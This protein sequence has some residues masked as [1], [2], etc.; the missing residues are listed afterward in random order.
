MRP[1]RGQD[2]RGPRPKVR[3]VFAEFA[4]SSPS[5]PRT[6]PRSTGRMPRRFSCRARP[7]LRHGQLRRRRLQGRRHDERQPR[8]HGV[9]GNHPRHPARRGSADRHDPHPRR[10]QE[11]RGREEVPGLHGLGRGADQVERGGGPAADQQERDRD[12]DDPFLVAGFEMLSTATGGIAQF[13]DRDAP[14]EMAKA[15]MEGFQQ[16]MV[17]PEQLDAILSGSSRR[18]SASTSDLTTRGRPFRGA[19]LPRFP[20]GPAWRS[21]NPPTDRPDAGRRGWWRW[22]QQRLTP[23]LFLAPGSSCSRSTCSGRSSRASGCRSTTGTGSTRRE[24]MDRLG[25]LPELRTDPAFETSLRNNVI[26]LVLYMLAMPGGA[27]H[28]DLPEPDGPRHP[29]L[30]VA[31]LL[32]LRDQPGRRRP[33]LLVVL[34]AELRAVLPADRTADGGRASR[35]SPTPTS[36]PTA[37]SPRASGRR[38]P[39]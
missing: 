30:Q 18:A 16:F 35:S 23:W 33:D 29:A 39:M 14:A 27:L 17:Q 12:A 24:G 8:L 5:S 13:F 3:A 37:S 11:R 38:S 19:A 9:P 7:P 22:N 36:S 26:W 10:R 21:S 1:D 6:T 4:R 15:G 20:G 2:L 28:R 25:E 34:R 31:V 32:P